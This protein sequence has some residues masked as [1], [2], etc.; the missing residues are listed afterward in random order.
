MDTAY[1]TG[2]DAW[3]DWMAAFGDRFLE[4]AANLVYQKQELI[5]TDSKANYVPVDQSTLQGSGYVEP[6][7]IGTGVI[8][9][10]SA[11]GGPASA[12]AIAIHEHLSKSSPRSW[13]IAEAQGRHV[14][15]TQGGPKYLELPFMAGTAD[16]D[17]YMA[18]GL[19]EA[20]GL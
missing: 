15:F 8:S 12:Y 2:L 5:M 14:H 18:D 11:Y 17:A 6:P 10:R 4:A 7:V 20:L 9:C 19:A 1:T 16:F 13:K 3:D